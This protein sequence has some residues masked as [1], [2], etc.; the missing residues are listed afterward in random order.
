MSTEIV[1]A[2]ASF[3]ILESFLKFDVNAFELVV[4]S[5]QRAARLA[6]GEAPMHDNNKGHKYTVSALMDIY[7][8]GVPLIQSLRHELDMQNRQHIQGEAPIEQLDDPHAESFL[9][10]L[11][12]EGLFE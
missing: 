2:S 1:D 7:R 6:K 10:D 5:A 11:Q 12:L 4:L 8:G 3:L 9:Y